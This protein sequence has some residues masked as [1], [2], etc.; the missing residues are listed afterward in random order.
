VCDNNRNLSDEQLRA[1]AATG[2]VIGVGYWDV[3]SCGTDA[4]SIAKAIRY[5]VSLVGAEHV[6]L[7]SDF[8]GAVTEPFD[9][10]G[11]ALITQALLEQAM[12]EHDIRLVMG[13][14]VARVLS[15]VLP[16]K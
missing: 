9:S 13:E 15:Q 5:T 3:A 14:N 1:V 4:A 11:M 6:G 7:G 16:E 8:D 2:G 12:S 10:S